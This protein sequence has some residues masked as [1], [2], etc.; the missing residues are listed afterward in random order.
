MDWVS[1]AGIVWEL[2]VVYGYGA[3]DV[4]RGVGWE[5]VLEV[6]VVVG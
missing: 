5:G 1:V 3:K 6:R 4:G 2:F